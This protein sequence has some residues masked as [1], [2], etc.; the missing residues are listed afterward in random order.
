MP[1]L[2]KP[3]VNTLA[4]AAVPDGAA[5]LQGA[6]DQMLARL[7]ARA[8]EIMQASAA[9]LLLKQ[10]GTSRMIASAGLSKRYRSYLWSIDELPYNRDDQVTITDARSHPAI[11]KAALDIGLTSAGLF[12][13][14]PVIVHDDYVV[15]LMVIDEEPGQK[16]KKQ[17]RDLMND[18]VQL[19][20]V[21]FENDVPVL[22]NPDADVTVPMQLETISRAVREPGQFEILLDAKLGIIAVSPA[23]AALL[24]ATPEELTGKPITDFQFSGIEPIAFFCQRALQTHVSP[25]DFEIML[26]D[27]RNMRRVFQI[28]VSPLSPTDTRDYF[29]HLVVKEI[30][31]RSALEDRLMRNAGPVGQIATPLEPSLAFLLETLIERRSLRARKNLTYL[32]LRSWRQPIRAY[33]IK[34]LRALKHN[35][36]PEMAGMIATEMEAELSSLVGPSAFKAIVPVPCGH[37][38]EGPCLSV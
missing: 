7:C 34:A 27:R 11:Q 26:E 36:P 32:T 35:L 12:M 33:Q 25:P 14:M 4:E 24:R 9:T 28:S 31:V 5:P 23:V 19:V 2:T 37:T 30:T 6:P 13:R 3:P 17:Q 38:R 20:R 29:L 21:I 22:A 15:S 18:I 10:N 1:R 8:A 16:P